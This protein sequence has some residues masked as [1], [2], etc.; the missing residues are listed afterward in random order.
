MVFRDETEF[1][2][3]R[4]Y[5]VSAN[6]SSPAAVEQHSGNPSSPKTPEIVS[7]NSLSAALT[8]EESDKS[9]S[10][11]VTGELRLGKTQEGNWR[12]LSVMAPQLHS[13][14]EARRFAS[15][16]VSLLENE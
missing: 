11:V 14:R 5:S 16:V 2:E 8:G 1:E 7:S 10:P 13:R 3:T 9:S 6:P 12:A 15:E 4:R